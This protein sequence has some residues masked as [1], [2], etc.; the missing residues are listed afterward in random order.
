MDAFLDAL[1]SLFASGPPGTHGRRSSGQELVWGLAILGFPLLDFFL[2]MQ[3]ASLAMFLPFAFTAATL[4]LAVR[5]RAGAVLTLMA[6]SFCFVFSL[7]ASFVGAFFA[8][9]GFF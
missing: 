2:A 7:G 3:S 6:T 9:G 4:L 1:G 5:V 8:P